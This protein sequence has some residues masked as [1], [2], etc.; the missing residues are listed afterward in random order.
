MGT[1]TFDDGGETRTVEWAEGGP[2]GPQRYGRSR[3][4]R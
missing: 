3:E 1:K 4:A 2:A